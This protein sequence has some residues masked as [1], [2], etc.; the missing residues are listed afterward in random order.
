MRSYRTDRIL[1]VGDIYHKG[2][3]TKIEQED[4]GWI[5]TLRYKTVPDKKVFV[6]H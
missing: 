6:Y 1:S 2:V 3:V 4:R 5:L